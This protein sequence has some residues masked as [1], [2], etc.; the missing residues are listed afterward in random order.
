V[1][2]SKKLLWVVVFVASFL[3]LAAIRNYFK[4]EAS[5][6][7][8]YLPAIDASTGLDE[9]S[10]SYL[11]R[12]GRVRI[13]SP[14]NYQVV[15]LSEDA[16]PIV[17]DVNSE[18]Q[19]ILRVVELDIN[20]S[21]F[22]PLSIEEGSNVKLIVAGENTFDASLSGIEVIADSPAPTSAP[23]STP[24]GTPAPTSTP[25]STPT[26][27][28]STLPIANAAMN[29]KVTVDGSEWWVLKQEPGYT[30]LLRAEPIGYASYAPATP[31]MYDGSNLQSWLTEKWAS[32][33]GSK[34][35]AAAVT[36]NIEVTD[37][38]KLAEIDST[39]GQGLY[40]R[41]ALHY[42]SITKGHQDVLVAPSAYDIGAM[43]WGDQ[44]NIITWN[45]GVPFFIRN[46]F[47]LQGYYL[48]PLM[49]YALLL[50]NVGIPI[51]VRPMV[52]V[53]SAAPTPTPPVSPT[54]TPTLAP[55]P[56]P[57][58]NA[59]MNT[60]VTVDGAQWWVLLQEPGYTKLLSAESYGTTRY[61][62]ANPYMYDGSNLQ[63]WLTER[64]ADYEGSQL[65]AA[66]VTSNIEI[67]DPSK[68][69]TDEVSTNRQGWFAREASHYGSIT[70]GDLDVLVP[71]STYDIGIHGNNPES[72][73]TWS[74][75]NEFFI[76][77]A[78]GFSAGHAIPHWL[79][80]VAME[81]YTKDVR[82]MV[83]V[84]SVAP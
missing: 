2:G 47:G 8:D 75:G 81:G 58:A 19:V 9:E 72:K 30:K 51:A 22:S 29:T 7:V 38:S 79:A 36:S 59:A 18:E 60:K 39:N 14:G 71:P 70:K 43:Y 40:A 65:K 20:S 6:S 1:A 84:R 63:S 56:L 67:T 21:D 37:A 3:A 33:N 53:R 55:S 35:K 31:Y 74:T 45:T 48:D 73:V 46:A 49:Q 76:R 10:K 26:Q 15:Q 32:Y 16:H 24:S 41:E 13:S 42:G 44:T 82:P 4:T 69:A 61:N 64:W 57:I 77:N 25:S 78:D 52:W 17:V 68:L 80:Y 28:P 62:P 12:D 66:A 34:L 50:E 11:D 23:S 83:W 27:A 5:G 54:A